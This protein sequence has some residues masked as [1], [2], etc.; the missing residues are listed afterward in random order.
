MNET[1]DCKMKINIVVAPTMHHPYQL[2]RISHNDQ[3]LPP[4]GAACI[5]SFLKAKGYSVAIKDFPLFFDEFRD[6][7]KLLDSKAMFEKI[8]EYVTKDI[9]H[10]MVDKFAEKMLNCVTEDRC[11]LLGFSLL[12]R[13]SLPISL[14]LAKKVKQKSKVP[15][16]FGGAVVTEFFEQYKFNKKSFFFSNYGNCNFI[17]YFIVGKGM[18]PLLGLLEYLQGKVNIDKIPNLVYHKEGELKLNQ[19]VFFGLEE[20][21]VPDFSD[22]NLGKYETIQRRMSKKRREPKRLQLP[23]QITS[24]CVHKCSFCNF[25]L[26]SPNVQFKSCD[27][28]I[29]ELMFLKKKYNTNHFFFCESNVNLSYKYLKE[30]C[31]GIIKHK[32]DIVWRSVASI[33]N[34]DK[35]LLSLLKASGCYSLTWGIE[36]GSDAILKKMN[37]G[38]TASHARQVLKDAH[39]VGIHN[40]VNFITG[41]IHETKKDLNYTISF[42]KE[43]AAY[44]DKVRIFDFALA[45]YTPIHFH[46]DRYGIENIFVDYNSLMGF[47]RIGFDE[48]GGLKW[49]KKIKQKLKF[50]RM[51][52][53]A[54]LKQEIFNTIWKKISNC[55]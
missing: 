42:A 15:I 36:S 5:A 32:L 52:S 33:V 55:L 1:T 49:D 37:K 14:L 20:I 10:P 24:G 2:R 6:I 25:Y 29:R 48:Q 11:D 19:R 17:D 4:Y 23:Y 13:L 39:D 27:K 30:L 35:N 34:I 21:P 22:L 28:V 16:V 7:L 44:I 53:Q 45:F 12:S 26:V 31:E 47:S 3:D 51:A 46:P 43:N 40:T 8:T 9:P 50:Y 18:Y 38:F 54:I 41:F